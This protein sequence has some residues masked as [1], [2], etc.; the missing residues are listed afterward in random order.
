[1]HRL[2]RLFFFIAWFPFPVIVFCI[3]LVFLHSD[4]ETSTW[5]WICGDL[6]VEYI[7]A[8]LVGYSDISFVQCPDCIYSLHISNSL[9]AMT[10]LGFLATSMSAPKLVCDQIYLDCVQI[11]VNFCA[12][13]YL[14]QTWAYNKD[15]KTV[16]KNDL[17]RVSESEMVQSNSRREAKPKSLRHRC[18]AA[19][20]N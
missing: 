9:W 18:L 13:L 11:G 15:K 10:L 16:D 3:S 4:K 5:A 19:G 8:A 20:F 17:I 1:M 14:L 7:V 2:F 6:H 12:I